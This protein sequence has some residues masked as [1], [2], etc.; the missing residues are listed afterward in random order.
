MVTFETVQDG[1]VCGEKTFADH[2]EAVKYA[3]FL[4]KE[5]EPVDHA[6]LKLER[7]RPALARAQQALDSGMEFEQEETC[8]VIFPVGPGGEENFRCPYDKIGATPYC[9]MCAKMVTAVGEADKKADNES[10]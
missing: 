10:D 6:A 2:E 3:E 8:I 1:W 7:Y 4:K 5:N 9:D